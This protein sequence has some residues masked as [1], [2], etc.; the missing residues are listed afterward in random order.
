MRLKGREA[1]ET[2]E[3]DV[4]DDSRSSVVSDSEDT[5]QEER[6]EA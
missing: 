5:F 2:Y 6:M 3:R 4:R 1:V